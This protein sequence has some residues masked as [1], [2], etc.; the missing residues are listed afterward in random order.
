MIR[1]ITEIA[2]TKKIKVLA[3]V[4]KIPPLP[5]RFDLALVP[6]EQAA[7]LSIVSVLGIL[8]IAVCV[9]LIEGTAVKLRWTK[10]PE[11]IA[12]AVAMSLFCVFIAVMRN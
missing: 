10:M 1:K 7:P 3:T 2:P 6:W 5:N 12:F 9:A 11:F 4:V 8:L